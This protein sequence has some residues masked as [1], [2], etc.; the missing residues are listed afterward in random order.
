LFWD[1]HFWLWGSIIRVAPVQGWT[2]WTDILASE[3]SA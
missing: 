2:Y 3:F 1:N